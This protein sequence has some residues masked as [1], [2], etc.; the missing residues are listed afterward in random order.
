MKRIFNYILAALFLAAAMSLNTSCQKEQQPEPDK[1]TTPQ[2]TANDFEIDVEPAVNRTLY[3][4]DTFDIPF[5]ITKGL[6]SDFS[7]ATSLTGCSVEVI[8]DNNNGI[9]RVKTEAEAETGGGSVTFKGKQTFRTDIS[10]DTYY[11]RTDGTGTPAPISG[12]SQEFNVSLD[13]NLPFDQIV[14]ESDSRWIEKLEAVAGEDG[15]PRLAVKAGRNVT[16]SQR[17]ASALIRD[18]ARRLQ[19]IKLDIV[20]QCVVVT[21]TDV[22]TFKDDALLDAMVAIADTDGDYLVSFEEALAVEEIDIRGKGITDLTGIGAFKKAWKLDARDNDIVDATDVKGMRQLYWLDLKG[23]MNLKTFDITGCT[24]YFEHLD[25]EVTEN[26]KY[27][28]LKNQVQKRNLTVFREGHEDDSYRFHKHIRDDRQSADWSGH[29][30]IELI[31]EHTTGEGWPLVVT[32][33][34]FIDQDI[35][36]GSMQRYLKDA[37][38]LMIEQ[39]PDKDFIEQFDFYTSTYVTPNRNDHAVWETYGQELRE[40]QYYW[41]DLQQEHFLQLRQKILPG[42]ENTP[43]IYCSYH[44]VSDFCVNGWVGVYNPYYKEEFLS[45]DLP[46]EIK[47]LGLLD[48]ANLVRCSSSNNEE[49]YNYGNVVALETRC[50]NVIKGLKSYLEKYLLPYL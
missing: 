43:L 46:R 9:L 29:M 32:G 39:A 18:A 14:A 21:R 8:L 38:E 5:K 30:Q 13:T 35:E 33:M 26:L 12:E 41:K 23:N 47:R 4:G 22:V 48:S 19:P 31:K 24:I 16:E 45:S 3:R 7:I 20:Q 6:K 34:G 17:T 1:P 40:N 15:K 36:D 44:I 49:H 25:F 11:L 42:K 2:V 27:Y 28:L 10:F 50:K 37:V